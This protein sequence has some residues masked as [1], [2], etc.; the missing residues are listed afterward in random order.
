MAKFGIIET[1]QNIA[2]LTQELSTRLRALTFSDN[3]DSFETEVVEITSGSTIRVR[4]Q[5]TQTPSR[6]ILV[7]ATG[8]TNIGKS[9]ASGEEWDANYIYFKNYGSN[10]A[11]NVKIVI[12]R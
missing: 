9:D 8:E 11:T 12:M 5:L 6:Y 7:S 1:I 2:Q 3:F 4:N 10:T